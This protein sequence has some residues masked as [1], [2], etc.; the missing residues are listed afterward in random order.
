MDGKIK[1]NRDYNP[2]YYSFSPSRG[3]KPGGNGEQGQS[4]NY[5]ESD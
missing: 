4:Q 1:K 5:E 3:M 2:K